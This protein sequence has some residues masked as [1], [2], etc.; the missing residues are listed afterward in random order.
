MLEPLTG[1]L[2]NVTGLLTGSVKK[3]WSGSMLALPED[4]WA[5]ATAP[6]KIAAN[7]VIRKTV[8]MEPPGNDVEN[9]AAGEMSRR[10]ST[11]NKQLENRKFS[12][13]QKSI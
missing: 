4:C 7:A 11:P 3:M 2:M 10:K 9:L 6:A 5:A 13:L 8:R 12:P 1:S